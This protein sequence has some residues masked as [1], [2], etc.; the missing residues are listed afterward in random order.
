[1]CILADNFNRPAALASGDAAQR[2]QVLR[3]CDA[4]NAALENAYMYATLVK[5]G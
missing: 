5:D 2:N 1:M 3:F 4:D